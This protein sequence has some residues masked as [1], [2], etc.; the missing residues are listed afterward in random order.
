MADAATAIRPRTSATV[1]TQAYPEVTSVSGAE[2]LAAYPEPTRSHALTQPYFV[3]VED[4]STNTHVHPAVH[5][6]FADDDQDLI[7]S[8]VMDNL[9]DDA[10][11]IPS[12]AATKGLAGMDIQSHTDDTESLAR[13][14]TSSPSTREQRTLIIDV[15]ADGKQ[16]LAAHS[17][18][19]NWQVTG[20]AISQAPSWNESDKDIP[21]ID[22]RMMLKIDGTGLLSPDATGQV[23][24]G[25]GKDVLETMTETVGTVRVDLAR[26]RR[27]LDMDVAGAN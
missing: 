22:G 26:L 25:H 4:V 6:V 20:A 27:L 5:Y 15:S 14:K 23:T 17:L 10:N 16:V 9:A 18:N 19:S 24:A 21:T 1:L 2:E 11:S 12:A 7:A 13:Q 8:A 3:V